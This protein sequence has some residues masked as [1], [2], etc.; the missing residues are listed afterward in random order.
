MPLTRRGRSFAAV[1]VALAMWAPVAPAMAQLVVTESEFIFEKAPFASAHA[2]TIV[3]TPGGLVTAWFAGTREGASDVGIW[4]SRRVEGK[5]TAPVEVADGV[6]PDGARHPTWNPV[7]FE[8]RAG[9][10]TLFYKVGPSPREWWGMLRTSADNGKTWST[11]RRLPDGI[12]GPIKNKPIRLSNGTIIAPSSTSRRRPKH[13]ACA[14]R[15][16]ARFGALV[17]S[18]APGADNRGQADRCHSAQHLDSAGW[19]SAGHRTIAFGA[20]VRDRSRDSGGTWL[21]VTLTDLPNPNAGI[22]AIT[23]RDQRHLLSKPHSQ[24]THAVERGDLQRRCKVGNGADPRRQSRRIFVSGRHSDSRWS[25]NI[26]YTCR[27]ERIKH[28]T[29]RAR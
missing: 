25:C 28:V 2:S 21:A 3:E 16:H 9:E 19:P 18:R 29:V 14:L 13:V 11:A 24:R 8:M 20:R 1:F 23:L 5:W 22:D 10:L 4:V 15:N 7:L 12:L 27:R 17:E 6:Q 26:T